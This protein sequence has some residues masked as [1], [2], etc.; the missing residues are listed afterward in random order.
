MLL[1]LTA[2]A[3]TGGS[4]AWAWRLSRRHPETRWDWD[5][6]DLSDLHFPKGFH[7]GTATAAHQIEGGLDNNNWAWWEQQVRRGK[8][9][10]FEGQRVGQACDSY[11]RYRD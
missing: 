1:P 5:R 11:N 6:L 2:A 4:A 3:L 9:T 8:P 7:W 10:I